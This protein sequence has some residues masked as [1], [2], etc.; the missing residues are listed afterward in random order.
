MGSRIN[1]ALQQGFIE[2]VSGGDLTNLAFYR[3]I[4]AHRPIQSVPKMHRNIFAVQG[5]IVQFGLPPKRMWAP[6]P[7]DPP[8]GTGRLQACELEDPD[9][10]SGFAKFAF[11][12]QECRFCREQCLSHQ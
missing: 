2:R 4:Q 3:A 11:H 8:T 6:I 9:L 10:T 7:D 1:I 12:L 5:C